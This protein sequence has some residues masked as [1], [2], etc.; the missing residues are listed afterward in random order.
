MI[1]SALVHTYRAGAVQE[2][3]DLW[4]ATVVNKGK[5]VI[6]HSFWHHFESYCSNMSFHL[7]IHLKYQSDSTWINLLLLFQSAKVQLISRQY[8]KKYEEKIGREKIP[9]S[10]Y[11]AW[12]WPNKAKVSAWAVS[13]LAGLLSRQFEVI[14][15]TL[16][17]TS[18]TSV[19]PRKSEPD[20]THS[21][22]ETAPEWPNRSRAVSYSLF[23]SVL[24]LTWFFC[25]FSF[26]ASPVIIF[27][28]S[29]E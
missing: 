15:H 20:S 13:F 22:T 27:L 23:I 14:G 4:N 28:L 5:I 6:N 12:K 9:C 2:G 26:F 16:T 25:L 29:F 24:A 10:Q 3:Q 19:S 1:E 8:W 17:F 18:G 11:V 7:H 21:I